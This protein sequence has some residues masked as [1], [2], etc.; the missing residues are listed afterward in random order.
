[1]KNQSNLT[2]ILAG[3]I[4]TIAVFAFVFGAFPQGAQAYGYYGVTDYSNCYYPNA[5]SYDTHTCNNQ[6]A[7]QQIN[8]VPVYNYQP[9]YQQ[10][11]YQYL[12]L[13]VTCYPNNASVSVGS[14]VQWVASPIGGN[15]SFSYNWTGTD[16]LSGTGQT[17]YINYNNPGTKSASVT[18][19]SNGQSVS[20]SCSNFVTVNAVQTYYQPQIYTSY[21]NYGYNN[22]QYYSPLSASCVANTTYAPLGSTVTWTATATGGNG[23][24]Q[25]SWT[26]TDGV[27]GQGQSIAYNYNQPGTKYAAVTVYSNGQTLTESC[28][29][30]V[31][32]GLTG[33]GVV[34]GGNYSNANTLDIA[35]YS[36]PTTAAINQPVT[37]TAEVTRGSGQ[38][39]YNWSGTDNLNSTQNSAIKFYSTSGLK[40][41]IVSVTSS[42][43]KTGTHACSMT[44]RGAGGTVTQPVQQAVRPAQPQANQNISAGALFSFNNVPWGWV[45]VLIILILFAT[46]M[47]LLFNKPKI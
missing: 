27:Y 32:V 41:A 14:S 47:Y 44:V 34:I 19:Y 10:P 24:Y 26:G 21:S 22:Y 33:G 6:S 23:Y 7:P 43:G 5:Y 46:V 17:S 37:W 8:Y 18:V 12:P 29:N 3:S 11:Q 39:T 40:T 2:P 15:G 38:Y 31:N 36:D 30:I 28:A 45:A 9:Q 4:L 1:M 35:C 13:S 25:Y 42:D 20:A 16:G